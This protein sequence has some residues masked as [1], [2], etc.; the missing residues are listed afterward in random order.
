MKTP[1]DVVPMLPTV[2]PEARLVFIVNAASGSLACDVKLLKG[3]PVPVPVQV[4]V[5]NEQSE[6]IRRRCRGLDW[7]DSIRWRLSPTCGW[8]P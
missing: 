5:V 3:A 1:D 6:A 2:D 4:G 8:R 7:S